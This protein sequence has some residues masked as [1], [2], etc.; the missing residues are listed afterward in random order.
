MRIDRCEIFAL[1]WPL[2]KVYW[3]SSGTI[4]AVHELVVRLTTDDGLTGIGQAHGKP[5]ETLA[6]IVRDGLAPL[7][8]DQDPLR[9]EWHWERMFALT[10]DRRTATAGWPRP[11][12]MAAI[13]AVDI[14]LWDLLGQAAGLPLWR[15]LGGYSPRVRGYGSG[16]YY[17]DGWTPDESAKE[18][19]GYVAQGFG[20]VKMKVGGV[21]IADDVRR[22]A[23]VREAIGPD[24]D[25]LLD[26]NRAYSVP[27]AVEAARAFAPHDIFWFEDTLRWNDELSGLPILARQSPIRLT[28]GEPSICSG[29]V[30]NLLAAGGFEVLMYDATWGGGLTEAR[31]AAALAQAHHVH[32]SPHHDPQIHVHLAAALPH[33]LILETFPDA[34]RDPLWANLFTERAVIEDGY[35]IAPDR[36]GLGV[37]L[38]EQVLRR[39]ARLVM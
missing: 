18:M 25:L 15:L 27:R 9:V 28:A 19:A 12:L 16:G 20:A 34:T 3:T 2:E 10:T 11:A 38:D 31:R 1:T 35:V 32:Y 36:P 8:M 4:D 6:K 7:V 37:V 5:I 13:A 14:A 33:T 24:V 22:V 17:W 26:A 29:D 21:S 23:A 30:R 39:H